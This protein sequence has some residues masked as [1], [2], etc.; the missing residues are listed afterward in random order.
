M[1]P[2]KEFGEGSRRF[3]KS[4]GKL[5]RAMQEELATVVAEPSAGSEGL[6]PS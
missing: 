3:K 2:I 5:P 6:P 4:V 1:D